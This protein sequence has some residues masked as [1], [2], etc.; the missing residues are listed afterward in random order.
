MTLSKDAAARS[1]AGRFETTRKLW[2]T[3]EL[4]T[5]DLVLD[6]YSKLP[7]QFDA[8]PRDV[9]RVAKQYFVRGKMFVVVVGD[10]QKIEA[11]LQGFNQGKVQLTS[12]DATAA[13]GCRPPLAR[14]SSIRGE[15]NTFRKA[16]PI[17]LEVLT[18]PSAIL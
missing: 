7:A 16:V 2:V 11:G 15:N 18:A 12:Y 6:F 3:T 10:E 14:R 1:L 5:Y 17:P 8:D 9:E 4:F 13:M